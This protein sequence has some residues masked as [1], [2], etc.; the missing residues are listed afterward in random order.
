MNDRTTS[1]S[2]LASPIDST[3]LSHPALVVVAD[4][5]GP[6]ANAIRALRASLRFASGDQPPRT[7]LL[8]SVDGSDSAGWLAANLAVAF[9]LA[10]DRTLLLDANPRQPRLHEY[11]GVANAL[12]VANYLEDEGRS[13]PVVG[14]AMSGLSIVPAGSSSRGAAALATP[15]FAALLG[16]ARE[17]ADFAIV[18]A[19]PLASSADVLGI[20]PL[21]EGVVL[22]IQAGKT[23]RP[24]AIRVKEQLE[25]VGARLLGV[26]LTGV[27]RQRGAGGY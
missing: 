22:V 21:M 19:A 2:S 9:V 4:P 13:L 11:F 24:A 10:G 3:G 7:I 25:R 5:D 20:A 16:A 8:A 18:D 17:V 6:E 15:R 23:K 14:T 26:A 27:P 12:G 1:N